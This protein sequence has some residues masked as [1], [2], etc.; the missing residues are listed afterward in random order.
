MKKAL[1]L[2]F[3]LIAGLD[4]LGQ[5][6]IREDLYGNW[7]ISNK[8]SS[9]Y[10]SEVV[11]LHQDANYTYIHGIESCDLVEWRIEKNKFSLVDMY[12]C[13]EPGIETVPEQDAIHFRKERNK[14]IIEIR[15]GDQTIDEFEILEMIESKANRHP[16]YIKL[17]RL[18]RMAKKY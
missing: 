2:F 5:K 18:K 1:I 6:L 15:R 4:A 12:I 8:D 14:Q 7:T 16:R 17:L 10:K 9:Y 11:E 3:I 13:S